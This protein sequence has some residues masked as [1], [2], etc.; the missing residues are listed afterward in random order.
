MDLFLLPGV[1]LNQLIAPSLNSF[2]LSCTSRDVHPQ[3]SVKIRGPVL[4]SV[5]TA[6]TLF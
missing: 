1:A 2:I 5:V 3:R 6:T 4:A